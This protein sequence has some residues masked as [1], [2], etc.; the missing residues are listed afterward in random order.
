MSDF[1]SR[2]QDAID[3]RCRAEERLAEAK[4]AVEG[5][6][7]HVDQILELARK[8]LSKDD[9]KLVEGHL[10]DMMGDTFTAELKLASNQ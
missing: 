1:E 5:A 9:A 10:Y 4:L 7:F 2:K 3:D 8:Y 6:E